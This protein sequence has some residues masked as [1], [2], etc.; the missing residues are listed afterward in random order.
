MGGSRPNHV[1]IPQMA[2]ESHRFESITLV[3][4]YWD[5][6]LADN[7]HLAVEEDLGKL[8]QVLCGRKFNWTVHEYPIR[9]EML[10]EDDFQACV[11]KRIVEKFAEESTGASLLILY[12]AGHADMHAFWQP[13]ESAPSSLVSF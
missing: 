4:V 9:E 2:P 8:K 12:Y 1:I 3:A 6:K 11:E 13:K 5:K 7:L 10:D